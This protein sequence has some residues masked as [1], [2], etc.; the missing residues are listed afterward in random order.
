MS[1]IHYSVSMPHPETHLF[2][3]ELRIEDIQRS[4]WD[5]ILPSWTAGSYLIREFARHVQE[6]EALCP[7]SGQPLAWHKVNKN[8]WRVEHLEQVGVVVPPVGQRS[9][10]VQAV[11]LVGAAHR[12][13]KGEQR[14]G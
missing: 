7:V 12:A 6:F 14:R 3:V 11:P 4:T 13:E 8:T 5:L 1:T 2:W 10:H 9:H